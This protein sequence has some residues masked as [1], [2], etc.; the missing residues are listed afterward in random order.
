MH[1]FSRTS[2]GDFNGPLAVQYVWNTY[3]HICM[4]TKNISL[5]YTQFESD[6]NKDYN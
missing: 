4:W 6:L 1:N 3:C 5:F 2:A